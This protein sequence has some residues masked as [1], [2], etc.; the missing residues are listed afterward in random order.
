MKKKLVF[1]YD[2]DRTA[3]AEGLESIK[4]AL[5][6]KGIKTHSLNNNFFQTKKLLE[7]DDTLSNYLIYSPEAE[8][9][10]KC[11][12]LLDIQ[13]YS[14]KSE[15][16]KISDIKSEIGSEDFYLDTFLEK[17]SKFFD[18]KKRVYDFKKF[19]QKD[20]QLAD[21]YSFIIFILALSEN[22]LSNRIMLTLKYGRSQEDTTVKKR[23][24][25]NY[26]RA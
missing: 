13:L 14:S 17:Y 11:N 20:V 12:W 4:S 19:Y 3:D 8:R 22:N 6:E 7:N 15:N 18:N 23:K 21:N 26:P 24:K 10:N 5:A 9:K 16:S 2:R 1:W 25:C